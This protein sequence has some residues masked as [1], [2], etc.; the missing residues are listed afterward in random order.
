V[1]ISPRGVPEWDWAPFYPAGTV[2]SKV[3]DGALADRMA[4]WGQVG[5][6]GSDFVV[7]TFLK[8]HREYEW[9]H[10]LLKDMKCSPWS[11]IAMPPK[12]PSR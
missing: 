10:G 2:Q 11:L 12:S 9:M 7:E 3:I 8:D 4:F 1:E 6:H 5:H